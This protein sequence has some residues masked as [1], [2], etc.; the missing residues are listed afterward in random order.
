M[1]DEEFF[2]YMFGEEVDIRIGTCG[3]GSGFTELE[4]ADNIRSNLGME[5]GY[6][7]SQSNPEEGDGGNMLASSWRSQCMSRGD[8]EQNTWHVLEKITKEE[9]F[10]QIPFYLRE[11]RF[12]SCTEEQTV[13]NDYITDKGI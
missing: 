10:A 12:S 5:K 2:N 13:L 8:G 1:S 4:C 9:V 7:E 3:D 11:L 6:W